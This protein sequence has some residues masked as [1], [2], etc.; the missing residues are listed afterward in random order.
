MSSRACFSRKSLF[1]IF[2]SL[3]AFATVLTVAAP[4]FESDK[5]GARIKA[6]AVE[7]DKLRAA[8]ESHAR[9][10]FQRREAA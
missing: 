8:A 9:R 10:Q 5:L 1:A 7:R 6:V 4:Y 2:I 3:A